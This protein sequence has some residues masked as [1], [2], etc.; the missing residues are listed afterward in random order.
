MSFD[1]SQLKTLCRGNRTDRG[2]TQNDEGQW[3][4]SVHDRRRIAV[5]EMQVVAEVNGLPGIPE[6]LVPLVLVRHAVDEADAQA[7]FDNFAAWAQGTPS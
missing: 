1:K 7:L 5:A 3:T 2:W 6:M 4:P